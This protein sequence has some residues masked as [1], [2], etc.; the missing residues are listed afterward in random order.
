MIKNKIQV[1]E[2]KKIQDHRGWFLKVIDGKEDNLPNMTGEFYITVATPNQSKGGHYHPIANEWFTLIKGECILEL[3]DVETKEYYEIQL[4]E[5]D[6]KTIYVPKKIAHNFK[7]S[8]NSEFILL[9][10]SDVLYDPNDTIM[11]AF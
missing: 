1:I 4:S 9:A 6:P 5:N 11:Y 7:N 8:A 10:Y 2:R 3:V